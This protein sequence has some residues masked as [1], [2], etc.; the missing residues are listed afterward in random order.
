M[1]TDADIVPPASLR[2]PRPAAPDPSR[3]FSDDEIAA[4]VAF[5]RPRQRWGLIALAANLA[6]LANLA[7]SPAGK[8][9]TAAA[10]RVGGG[11]V[12]AASALVAALLAVAQ[13]LLGLPFGVR[14]WRQ[15]RAAGLSTQSLPAWL[16]DWA[17]GRGVGLVLTGGPLVLLVLA[18]NHLPGF[19]GSAA[20]GAAML[21]LLLSLVSP[22]LLE[23]IFNRFRPL[24]AGPLRTEVLALATRMGVGVREVLVAD[25]SR[26]TRRVNAYVSGLGRTR[27][28]VLYDTLAE[29]AAPAEVVLVLA[30]E[31]AHVRHRDVMFGTLAGA[32]GA[33]LGV[34][35]LDWALDQA[36]AR[37]LLGAAGLGD[38]SSLPG[39]VLLGACFGLLAAPLAN[40]VSRWSEA[41]ADWVALEAT[42]DPATAVAVERRLALANR[43]N[44]RPNRF[45]VTWF[46][47]HPP[48]M[49][50]IAQ[51]WLWAERNGAAHGPA[52]AA[53][54]DP[55]PDQTPAPDQASV[56]E[57]ASAPDQ[58]SVPALDRASNPVPDQNPDQ[59]PDQRPGQASGAAPPPGGA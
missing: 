12:A 15:D 25:A 1:R 58:A 2:V 45:L 32:V 17:K 50:R 48:A 35:A 21:V 19:P 52:R 49:A 56:R 31:L 3:A 5:A 33:G 44:L 8:D 39:V 36:A 37:S 53:A 13:G 38:P 4:S 18:A 54:S 28:V 20:L 16:A 9:L 46:A 23:P 40:A 10:V 24:A 27:R 55:P 42:R 30:H 51:A 6:L 14:A 26:R 11:S 22:V 57:E 59:R 41:R 34:I 29:T 7:L 43:A 47:T